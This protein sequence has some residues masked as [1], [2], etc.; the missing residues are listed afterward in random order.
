MRNRRRKP[1]MKTIVALFILLLTCNA[2]GQATGTREVTLDEAIRIALDKNYSAKNANLDLDKAEYTRSKAGDNLLPSVSGTA[3]YGLTKPLTASQSIDEALNGTPAHLQDPTH[4]FNYSISA[5]FNV[6]N[7]GFDAANIRSADYQLD[8]A[9]YNLKW[10]RQSVAFNTTASYVNALRTKELLKSASVTYSQ[11]SALLVRVRA[12]YQAGATAVNA[13]Y[14]Q[15]A[16]V[17]Q[18]EL[19]RIQAKNNYDNA[20]ADLLFTL[21]LPPNTYSDFDVSLKGIDTSIA[22]IR[23][24]VSGLEATPSTL[25]DLLQHREDLAAQRSTI[26]AQEE[27]I[28]ITRSAL[29]P[30]LDVS[31]GVGGAGSNTDIGHIPFFNN[32][33]AGLT[34]NVPI[35]DKMQNRLQIDIEKV[36]LE[37]SRVV[38]DQAEQQFRSDI[39]KAKNNL[40]ASEQALDASNRALIS[41]EESLRGAVERLKV[42]AGIQVEVVVAEAQ[43]QTARVNKINAMFNYLLAE[44]QL[45]Y[46]LGRTNY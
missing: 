15:E 27:G 17:G 35:F 6:F 25:N 10:A 22:A 23:S 7:G 8:A 19:S 30:S 9:R 34:L 2:F 21:D 36:Q 29:L 16:I 46:L 13:V 33:T 26:L 39:A 32:F 28:A 3:G 14:Q 45:E 12:Q 1:V 38:L 43:A 44:K 20:I 24:R 41:A 42:G 18:D 11:D 4:R 37:Q 5:F 40:S 31:A